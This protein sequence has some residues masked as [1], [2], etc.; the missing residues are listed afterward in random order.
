VHWDTLNP[1]PPAAASPY[2]WSYVDDAF[3]QASVWDAQNP[4]LLPKTIQLIIS[5]GFQSPQWMLD[6]LPSCD[7]LFQSPVQPPPST[8]GKVTFE[9]FVEGGD[10]MQL[11]LPWNAVYKSAWKAF[12][13]ALAARYGSNS[14]FVSIAVAGPTAAWAEM[15][16]PNGTALSQ[17]Q[18]GGL[19]P[20]AVWL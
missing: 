9:G 19:S 12:L 4:A 5:A 1:N 2:D 15:L 10:S 7:G 6:Q 20:N 18:F 11:P 16:L 8:C 13:I 3:N 17:S 14:A